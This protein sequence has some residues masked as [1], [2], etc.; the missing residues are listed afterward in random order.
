MAH[1]YKENLYHEMLILFIFF[2]KKMEMASIF[3][4]TLIIQHKW[5]RKIY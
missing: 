3:S 5:F 1:S 4:Q 2:I